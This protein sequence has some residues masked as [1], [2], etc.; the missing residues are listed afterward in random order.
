MLKELFP[1]DYELLDKFKIYHEGSQMNKTIYRS[2]SHVCNASLKKHN[3]KSQFDVSKY[4]SNTS[5]RSFNM[6]SGK[7][8]IASNTRGFSMTNYS[9]FNFNPL[10]RTSFSK[11]KLEPLN[12]KNVIKSKD[13][14][15][16]EI[17]YFK[18]NLDNYN[19]FNRNNCEIDMQK[20]NKKEM[21]PENLNK[22]NIG[23]SN[24]IDSSINNNYC[25]YINYNNSKSAFLNNKKNNQFV[26]L[27]SSCNLTGKN[28]HK[29]SESMPII[30]NNL[31]INNPKYKNDNYY[32]AINNNGNNNICYN[33]S[34]VNEDKNKKKL[35]EKDI[36]KKLESFKVKLNAKMLGILKEEK[37]KE[38]ERESLY[39][40][41]N[42]EVEKK[43]LENI[44]NLE[45]VQSSE[46][47]IKINE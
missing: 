29:L 11:L 38:E 26:C 33:S 15:Q 43:R 25:N 37:Q 34:S 22:I 24:I 35:I 40:K 27:K 41:A 18:N 45:R 42:N 36:E 32:N 47:I 21:I 3:D 12:E 23:K 7:S 13:F 2:T 46:R 31:D 9:N 1:Y 4:K 30:S 19:D 10:N 16:E 5:F 28:W 20:P 39:N 17:D 8:K 14:S 44:I 6:A